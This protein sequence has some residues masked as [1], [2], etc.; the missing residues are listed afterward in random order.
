[1]SRARDVARVKF[2]CTTGVPLFEQMPVLADALRRCVRAFSLSFIRVDERC[3]PT[4]HYSEYFDEASHRLFATSR[5]AFATR[6]A[7][8]A[9]FANLLAGLDPVGRLVDF[10]PGFT[11]GP[12][13]QYFFSP[14]G[15]HHT[16]DVALRDESGPLAVLGLFRERR[17]PGFRAA[18]VEAMR[19]L[20]DHLVHACHASGPSA[21]FD[22]T[23][24]SMIVVDRLGSLVFASEDARARLAEVVFGSERDRVVGDGVVPDACRSL[25]ASVSRHRRPSRASDLAAPPELALPI[26]G[27]RLRLRAYALSTEVGEPSG[28]VGIQLSVEMSRS[29]RHLRVLGDAG[30]PPQLDRIA[31]GLVLG[32]SNAAIAADLEIG[33]TTLKSYQRD[34]YRRLDVDSGRAL[35][36]RVISAGKSLHLDFRRHRPVVRT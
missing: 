35:A 20:Y 22:E 33:A 9:A 2:L 26:P 7:D 21:G 8:P 32:R 4:E 10:P 3:A 6:S 27:G 18:D 16:L 30:L 5:E 19:A 14:N 34:L 24:S 28:L 36:E 15:I 12:V 29:A 11:D 23:S 17:A 31:W 13:Y 25:V 1:M